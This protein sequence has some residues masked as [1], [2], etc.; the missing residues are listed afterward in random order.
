M[1]SSGKVPHFFSPQNNHTKIFKLVVLLYNRTHFSHR[2]RH[3]FMAA[4]N[5][6]F[7]ECQG[8]VEMS[9]VV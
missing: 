3:D 6:S 2:G 1:P 9:T 4:A 7:L 8:G 5:A